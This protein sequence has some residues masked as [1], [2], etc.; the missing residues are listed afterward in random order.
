[1]EISPEVRERMERNR[2]AALVRKQQRIT[3]SS[4]ADSASLSVQLCS[5]DQLCSV[6]SIK[7][8]HEPYYT[9][10]QERVCNSCIKTNDEFGLVSQGDAKSC[11]LLTSSAINTLPFMEQMN[12]K[13]AQWTTM[14]LYLKKHVVA[15]CLKR[16]NTLEALAEEKSKRETRKFE[17]DLQN[18][19]DKINPAS[20]IQRTS[21][22]ASKK[23]KFNE[24]LAEMV[25]TI[26]GVP[27]TPS[28]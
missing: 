26:K 3:E 5:D 22:K 12:P 11:Y 2:Q 7:Q 6:C 14:K 19:E 27:Y 4:A 24:S 10:F 17:R 23:R 20:R 1:M 16:W 8:R 15:K 9:H 28:T 21:K 25:A 13:H 18:V